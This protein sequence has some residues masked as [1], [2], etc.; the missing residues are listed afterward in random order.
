MS[1]CSGSATQSASA[2]DRRATGR[3]EWRKARTIIALRKG[4]RSFVYPLRQF[5]RRRPLEGLD[6]VAPFFTSAEEAWEWLVAPNR[7]TAGKPP[8]E[9]LRDG[10]VAAVVSA[11]AGAFD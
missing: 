8:P 9:A 10:K 2:A 5:E 4:L 6:L 3:G 11:A 1:T 7:M